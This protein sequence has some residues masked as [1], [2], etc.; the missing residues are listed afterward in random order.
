M[1]EYEV[2]LV[3][4]PGWATRLALN[5]VIRGRIAYTLVRKYTT[6][7]TLESGRAALS[8]IKCMWVADVTKIKPLRQSSHS[9]SISMIEWL[10]QWRKYLTGKINLL[11]ALIE[12]SSSSVALLSFTQLCLA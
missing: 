3:R 12:L 11:R 6:V 9:S 7:E 4:S 10:G 8:C 2:V 5:K 1:L